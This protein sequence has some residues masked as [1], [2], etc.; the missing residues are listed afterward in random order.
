MLPIMLRDLILNNEDWMI[1]FYSVSLSGHFPLE[2][3][4]HDVRKCK[5]LHRE[6][7]CRSSCG[8][9]LK[10]SANSPHQPPVR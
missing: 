5:C 2:P 4:D 9:L 1:Q 7:T 10:L 6:T 3:S 8:E